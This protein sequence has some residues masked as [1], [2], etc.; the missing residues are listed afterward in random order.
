MESDGRGVLEVPGSAGTPINV[1]FELEVCDARFNNEL[2]LYRVGNALG[3]VG[4]LLPGEAG[5]AKAAL[6]AGQV[7][8]KRGQGTGARK[9][10]TLE[11]GA[12]YSFYLVQN[13]TT[14]RYLS[15]KAKAAPQVLFSLSAA[16]ADKLNHV[17]GTVRGET[18]R[19]AWEDLR[20][21]GHEHF[22]DAILSAEFDTP[23]AFVMPV[24]DAV[25][26]EAFIPGRSGDEVFQVPSALTAPVRAA[27]SWEVR[28]ARFNN[29]LGLYRVTDASGTVEG[30]PPGSPGYAQ[31]ALQASNVQVIFKSGAGAGASAEVVL[32]PGAY[33]GFYLIQNSSRERLVE[34]NPANKPG[35]L[36]LAFFSLA[37]ANPDKFDHLH[38]SIVG[39]KLHLEWE[40]LTG[41]GDK[42]FD[43]AVI[44]G[45]LSVLGSSHELF[46]YDA[47]ATD[48]D[49]DP[50]SFSLAAGPSGAAIDAQTGVLTWN[51]TL[52]RHA[53][54][55]RA[56]DGKGGITDQSFTLNVTPLGHTLLPHKSR[57]VS[58]PRK[59]VGPPAAQWQRGAVQRQRDCDSYRGWQGLPWHTFYS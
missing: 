1:T 31:A 40:D 34:R 21:R 59:G 47:E 51:A 14:S 33:Y 58:E 29:E 38:G 32:A 9:E 41:G 57:C 45:Q 52:G 36:P 11:G 25:L 46:R 37:G 30:L 44:T 35:R 7:I 48:T 27:F 10:V 18:L 28:N 4:T 13:S 24:F 20:N 26:L 55:I 49:G 12:L 43:D 8:F 39:G 22:D 53:F 17:H 19:L 2:G 6:T 3:Q 5:Y 54:T 50:I 15:S 16:N 42:D 56:S 23:P